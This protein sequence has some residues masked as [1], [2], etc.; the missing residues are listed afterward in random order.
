MGIFIEGRQSSME[1][2]KMT[3]MKPSQ[4]KWVRLVLETLR[5][6]NEPV[7]KTEL[8]C[9]VAEQNHSY[10]LGLMDGLA[11]ANFIR[12]E[13]CENDNRVTFVSLTGAGETELATWDI[14]F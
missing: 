13:I 11:Y 8:I 5:D 10:L 1:E 4:L 14:P 3:G 7:T 9:L 12:Y 6:W 2:S